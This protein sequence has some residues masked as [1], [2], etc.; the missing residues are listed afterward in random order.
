M[1]KISITLIISFLTIISSAFAAKELI[2]YSARKEKFVAPLIK[3]FEKD[4]GIKVKL[5]S[6]VKIA[7]ILAEQKNPRAN[8]FISN[9]VGQMEFLR[10]QGALTSPG[11]NNG[12]ISKDFKAADNSWIGLSARSRV[13][14]F[15]KNLISAKDM[16]KNLWD[17]T[18]PKYKGQFMITRG[19][20]GSMIAHVAALRTVWGDAKTRT[21]L[22]KI[23]ENAG[24]IT[25][26]HTQIRKG[27]GSGEFKF[28][29]VNNYYYHLQKNEKKNNSVDVVYP[30]QGKGDM[31]VFV[32][33]AG[34]AFIKNK[35]N[36]KEAEA[37]LNWILKNEHQAAFSAKSLETPLKKGLPHPSV[38]KNIGDYKTMKVPL[39]NLGKLW[40]KA[41]SL[42]EESGLDLEVK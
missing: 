5:L 16:P 1:Q 28:G 10:S 21:W 17:L 35:N 39:K 6:G 37:F 20:N 38:A 8:I 23:K 19:G 2:V 33:A 25:K 11:E 18:L 14:M 27:V 22:K 4:K 24:A 3:E 12:G 26:G 36:S 29:L 41:K 42:I 32:N 40:S 9:D 31:G 30:D 34:V 7:K 13:L 15:N